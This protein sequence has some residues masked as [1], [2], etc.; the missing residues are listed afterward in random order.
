MTPSATIVVV[1]THTS[2]LL[3]VNSAMPVEGTIILHDAADHRSEFRR[4]EAIQQSF[5]KT[6]LQGSAKA[7]QP[8]YMQ[9]HAQNKQT[10]CLI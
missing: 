1:Y 3:M 5:N 8:V 6:I 4:S 9:I 2:V 10:C 7:K